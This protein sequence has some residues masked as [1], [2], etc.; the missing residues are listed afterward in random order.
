MLKIF[1]VLLNNIDI[2]RN[3]GF[4]TDIITTQDSKYTS[5]KQESLLEDID[6]PCPRPCFSSLER[7]DLQGRCGALP[8][9][10]LE[11]VK[12]GGGG[13][14]GGG[15]RVA[16]PCL[17]ASR[18]RDP[19]PPVKRPTH[20]TLP[21]TMYVVHNISLKVISPYC[22]ISFQFLFSIPKLA[23]SQIPYLGVGG[24]GG[25]G[26]GWRVFQLSFSSPKKLPKFPIPIHLT[27]CLFFQLL[28]RSPKS[29]CCWIPTKYLLSPCYIDDSNL[30]ALLSGAG[31]V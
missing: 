22:W 1:R 15:R 5:Q 28:F 9:L 7:R 14:G 16:L 4:R 3:T 27:W 31:L 19:P 2:V 26:G 6:R 13:G 30:L 12:A 10:F 18:D 29:L 8:C 23:K 21:R 11:E 20:M 24:G 25:G 17:C